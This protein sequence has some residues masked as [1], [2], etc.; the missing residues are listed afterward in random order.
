MIDRGKDGKRMLFPWILLGA[1]AASLMIYI[2]I[3]TESRENEV[4]TRNYSEGWEGVLPG[5]G[6]F[7]VSAGDASF[8]DSA[9][10]P[11][12]EPDPSFFEDFL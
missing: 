10:E 8:L 5:E 2:F 7:A 9:G 12:L 4:K 11:F 3:L 6:F 1:I